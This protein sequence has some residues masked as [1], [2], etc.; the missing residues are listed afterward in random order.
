MNGIALDNLKLWGPTNERCQF[1]GFMNSSLRPADHAAKPYPYNLQY[2]FHSV[3]NHAEVLLLLVLNTIPTT[4][5]RPGQTMAIHNLFTKFDT[6][7]DITFPQT[8]CPH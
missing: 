6:S 2:H 1:N 7:E 3:E 8:A 5:A 4:Q